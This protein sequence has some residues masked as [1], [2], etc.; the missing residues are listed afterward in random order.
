MRSRYAASKSPSRIN[1]SS[2]SVTSVESIPD[3]TAAGQARGIQTAAVNVCSR[4]EKAVGAGRTLSRDEQYS[5][6]HGSDCRPRRISTTQL[7]RLGSSDSGCLSVFKHRLKEHCAR[8]VIARLRPMLD[9]RSRARRP[10][11][12]DPYVL[13]S[14]FNSLSPLFSRTQRE[15]RG[16]AQLS[17]NPSQL[18][19]FLRKII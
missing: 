2:T 19:I 12:P 11:M 17:L 13:Q 7:P 16:K 1:S 3:D 10:T 6:S 5:K 18:F 14:N 15:M 8:I 4:A 9:G